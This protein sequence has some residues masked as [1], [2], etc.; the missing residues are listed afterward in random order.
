MAQ[1]KS[2]KKPATAARKKPAAPFPETEEEAVKETQVAFEEP[3]VVREKF[4]ALTK[5]MQE[6]EI[7]AARKAQSVVPKEEAVGPEVPGT[8]TTKKGNV[9]MDR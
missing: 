5:G 1:E 8:F 9:R 3:E 2:G 7:E 6:L 4:R